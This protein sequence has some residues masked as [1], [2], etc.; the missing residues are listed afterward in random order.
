METFPY[1][2][3]TSLKNLQSEMYNIP[4]FLCLK[5]RILWLIFYRHL[6]PLEHDKY[7][8]H[9]PLPRPRPHFSSA[10]LRFFHPSLTPSRE[11]IILRIY[12]LPPLLL[13]SSSYLSSAFPYPLREDYPL[14]RSMIFHSIA[15]DIITMNTILIWLLIGTNDRFYCYLFDL[16]CDS[17]FSFFSFR[18]INYTCA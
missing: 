12:S 10:L 3:A 16:K 4:F 11:F 17:F 6:D 15:V 14:S 13:I 18:K 1:L 2:L 5:S 7:I 9:P 8:R